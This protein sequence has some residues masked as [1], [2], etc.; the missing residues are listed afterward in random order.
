M[1]V[2]TTIRN[3][4]RAVLEPPLHFYVRESFVSSPFFTLVHSESRMEK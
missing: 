2:A 1:K 4:Q 3:G